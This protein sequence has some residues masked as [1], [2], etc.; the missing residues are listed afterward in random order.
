[1]APQPALP[2]PRPAWPTGTAWVWGT[3]ALLTLGKSTLGFAAAPGGPLPARPVFE[4]NIRPI[5]KAKCFQCHGE[6]EKP[7]GGVDLRLR[8]FL[9]APHATEPVVVPGRPDT[10]RLLEVVRSGEM[11]KAGKALTPDQVAVIERW[12][13]QGAP[14]ARPEP[15]TVPAVVITEEERQHWAFQPIRRPGVP[16]VRSTRQVRT[17]VDRFLLAPLESERL[18]FAPPASPE[19]LIR[20]VT[21]DLTGLPPTPEEVAAFVADPSDEAYERVVDR[22][23]ASTAYGERWARHWLDVAGYADS[24]GGAE[25]DSERPWAWRYRDYVIRALNSDKP[26]DVFITEQLAG[27]ELVAQ[28]GAGLEGEDLDRIIATG[29]L[30]MAPDPTGD[31]PADADLARNQ[32]IADTLQIVSSSLL[33]LTVQCAQCHDHR[34][35]PI[36]QSDYYRLRAVF[37]PA[38]DWKQWKPPGQR[39]LSLMPAADR[40]AAERIETEAKQIDAEAT[41]LHDELIEKFV[42]KQLTLIPEAD[43]E[44][45][46]AARKTPAAKRTPDHL[47]LLRKH[48]TFQDHIILGEIDRPGA[49][50]VEEIRKRATAKRAEKPADPQVACLV[51]E[52]GR[53][54]QTV[55]FHRGDHQQPRGG[56]SP[57]LLTLQGLGGL[58][59]DIPS[60]NAATRTTGRRLELARRLTDR[61]NPLTARVLV[62]RVWLHHFGSGLVGT[63]GDFGALGERPTHPELLDWLADAFIA[64]G[65]R[66]KP[67]HR[68]LVTSAAYRQGTVNPSAQRRDPDNRLLGRA[69]LRRLDAESLRDGLLAVSG[70]LDPRPF[71]PPVPV[72]INPHGQCVVGRQKRDGNGDAV[73]VDA[74]GSD[75]FRRTVYVQ[76]RRS[77]PVGVLE[78]FDAPVVNPNCEVRALST[79]APQ[80][81]MFLNDAFILERSKDLAERLLREK[82]EDPTGRLVRLWL[83][84]FSRPPSAD[85]LRRTEAYLV[86]QAIHLAPPSGGPVDPKAPPKPSPEAQALASLCQVL[87]GSNE[88]LYVD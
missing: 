17:P 68:L 78:T 61:S 55:L 71:G 1:V 24:N 13:R 75:E 20:R 23:L 66:L 45:V 51:E 83:L 72:A 30:R 53:N 84:L 48:P 58:T 22:L 67:L 5:L 39:V 57:G 32:V 3:A 60:T 26:F 64:S 76:V 50:K 12:I 47:A 37:E 16:R 15:Q 54:L 31:G 14:T 65:W 40:A 69:R 27:D 87:M 52:P 80:S 25:A 29:F 59:I 86:R 85:E 21:F 88:F 81:L 8:R 35:D 28:P 74:L 82:P 77:T 44:P 62:N 46:M 38:F 4:R 7:K 2:T 6:E 56:V 9:T 18:G 73:G 11:P 41:R 43:R 79:V 70:R 42:Q 63:P 49:D 36:P 33:G 19:A 34:Y 10:S